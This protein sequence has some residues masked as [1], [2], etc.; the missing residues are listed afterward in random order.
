MPERQPE[1]KE[2]GRYLA[3]GQAGM[4]MV[5]PIVLG[6]ILDHYLGWTPWLT[7]I[8]AVIGFVGGLAHMVVIVN[9]LHQ[10]DSSTSRRGSP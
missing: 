7:V 4:E 6:L 8:G 9:R 1:P 2:L 10:S 3:L 5:A